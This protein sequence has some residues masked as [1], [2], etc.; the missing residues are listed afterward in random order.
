MSLIFEHE[1]WKHFTTEELRVI[2]KGFDHIDHTMKNYSTEENK[3]Y[4]LID[5]SLMG[6]LVSRH[7]EQREP[8]AGL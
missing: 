2:S 5:R 1:K 6:E 3:I 4:N 8:H 7:K